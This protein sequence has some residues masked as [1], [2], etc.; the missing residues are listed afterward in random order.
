MVFNN[1]IS[2]PLYLPQFLNVNSNFN[3]SLLEN[4]KYTGSLKKFQWLSVCLQIILYE[5][6][7]KRCWSSYF[8]LDSAI[9]WLLFS[10]FLDNFFEITPLV[11]LLFI[12]SSQ[13]VINIYVVTVAGFKSYKSLV[14]AKLSPYLNMFVEWF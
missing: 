2:N 8:N 3:K 1:K 9:P 11:S 5:K 4:N 13:H 10:G 7:N 14:V 6:R 12:F